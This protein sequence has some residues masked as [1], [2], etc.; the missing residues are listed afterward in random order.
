LGQG[1]RLRV[2]TS[3]DQQLGKRQRFDHFVESVPYQKLSGPV[4]PPLHSPKS[5]WFSVRTGA[6]E[7][8]RGN[9]NAVKSLVGL[10]GAPDGTQS[11][12]CSC[13]ATGC[14]ERKGVVIDGKHFSARGTVFVR[15]AI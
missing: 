15:H 6:T 3:V 8:D 1:V 5:H 7:T 10:K 13:L 14:E 12:G 4:S 11:F 9:S 2:A